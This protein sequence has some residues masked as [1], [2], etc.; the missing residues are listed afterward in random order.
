MQINYEDF[1]KVTPEEIVALIDSL[2]SGKAVTSVAGDPVKSSKA[3]AYETAAA[4]LG[5]PVATATSAGR[6]VGGE[7]L[8]ADFAPGHR[9]KVPG[10]DAPPAAE[11]MAED[12]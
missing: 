5:L 2:A 6:L 8:P 10:T 9:P 12:S 3:I 1:Y 7:S 4:G 11:D